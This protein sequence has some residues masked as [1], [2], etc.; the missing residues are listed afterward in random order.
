MSD[1]CYCQTNRTR[2]KME[3][4]LGEV[5]LS[6]F[7]FFGKLLTMVCPLTK[8]RKSSPQFDWEVERGI[9]KCP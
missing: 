6:S 7:Y 3:K 4:F 5:S 2:G 9:V 1:S 8:M